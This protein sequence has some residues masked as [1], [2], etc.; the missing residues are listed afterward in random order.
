MSIAY[1][2]EKQR[3]RPCRW[4]SIIFELSVHTKC[5]ILNAT[6]WFFG[7]DVPPTPA[8][9]PQPDHP[10]GFLELAH[11][12]TLDKTPRMLP[13]WRGWPDPPI[14][15]NTSVSIGNIGPFL[16]HL[17]LKYLNHPNVF[18]FARTHY[19]ALHFYLYLLVVLIMLFSVALLL[20]AVPM[21]FGQAGGYAQCMFSCSYPKS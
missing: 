3:N 5:T 4:L 11:S 17:S 6:T 21:A 8:S 19:S 14:W 20:C 9:S 16:H 18:L 12:I 2:R 15:Q 13:T 10:D 1:W 7:A